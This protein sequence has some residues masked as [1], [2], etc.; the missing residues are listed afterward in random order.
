MS[1]PSHSASDRSLADLLGEGPLGVH[2]VD[3]LRST[4]T[5]LDALHDRGVVHGDLSPAVVL[6]DGSGGVSLR[7]AA[8]EPTTE[9]SGPP[10]TVTGNLAQGAVYQPP[11]QAANSVISHRT[12]IYAFT[13]V[14]FEAIT[15]HPPF[16]LATLLEQASGTVPR[17]GSR[18]PDLPA[19]VDQ[20][21]RDALTLRPEDRPPSATALVASLE[22][23]F[24]TRYRRQA[25][26]RLR[27]LLWASAATAAITVVA[28]TLT[29]VLTAG[30]TDQP[31]A[32][33]TSTGATAPPAA[34]SPAPT[35]AR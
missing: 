34:P 29:A 13:C 12:D 21:F 32:P 20:V 3:V 24:G 10:A 18:R 35:G 11:E 17:A 22:S 15:G 19:A 2:S 33:A 30:T 8:S 23:A 16:T 27:R 1:V 28:A 6:I 26:T 7:P 14:A 9:G 31:A 4:A 25:G 5:E